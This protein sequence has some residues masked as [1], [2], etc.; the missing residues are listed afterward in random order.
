M[1]RDL[2]RLAQLAAILI[3]H[4]LGDL[5]GRL[6]LTGAARKAGQV[7]NPSDAIASVDLAP[8]Q[9]LRMALE[10][11]GP[12]FVKLGQILST[13]A[14][15]L[16]PAFIAEL[17]KLRDRVPP[18]PFAALRPSVDRRF[19]RDRSHSPGSRVDRAGSPRTA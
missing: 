14:D 13:R 9:R 2:G 10:E 8:P 6:G 15:L 16:P 19:R 11:M 7:F 5:I 17:E 4:G 18:V 12:T 1:Q 3:R